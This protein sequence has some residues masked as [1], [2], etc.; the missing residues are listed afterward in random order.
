MKKF[1]IA[2]AVKDITESVQDYSMRLG[3][4]PVCVIPGEYAL[5]RT[6]SLN[7]SIRKDPES[8]C[9]LRHLG[10]EDAKATQFSSEKDVN[11]ILW[12]SFSEEVQKEEIENIWP[13]SF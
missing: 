11:G 10:W 7:F 1:H 8:V 13:K 6:E 12:E 9:Q 2:L 4:Q 5:W 3:M